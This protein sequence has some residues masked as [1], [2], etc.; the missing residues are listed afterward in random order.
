MLYRIL[1]V[2]DS[3]KKKRRMPLLISTFWA[4][5]MCWRFGAMRRPTKSFSRHILPATAMPKNW[6]QQVRELNE[7]KYLE[8]D[9]IEGVKTDF[10][11]GVAGYPEKHGESPNLDSDLHF[12]KRKIDMGA[13]YVM[14]QMFF[15]NKH[16]YDYK[17]RCESAGIHVPIIPGLKPLSSQR[18]LSVVP[19]IFNVEI[20]VALTKEMLKSTS[21][22][23]ADTIGEEWLLEQC[24]DLIKVGV[25]ALHFYTL[26]KPHIIRNVL[27][28]LL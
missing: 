20:P 19:S 18:Q 14:T 17:E 8:E 9:V 11:I 24:R 5:I 25:P 6:L 22:D 12:L 28:R 4:W 21:K 16:Y 10:C 23:A 3:R 2:V 7:G 15:D 1:F 27:R 13:E 26:G